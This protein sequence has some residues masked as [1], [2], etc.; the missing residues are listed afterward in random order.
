MK[1]IEIEGTVYSVLEKLAHGRFEELEQ[2]LDRALIS[3]ET[4]KQ[5]IAEYGRHLV[6]PPPG[7]QSSLDV[8]PVKGSAPQAWSVVTPLWTREEGRSDLSLELTIVVG[9]GGC[10]ILQIENLHVR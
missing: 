9:N 2:S 4:M 3:A 5:A 10:R 8:V 6:V 1:P 7:W